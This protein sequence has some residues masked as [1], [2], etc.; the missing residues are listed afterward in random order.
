M[1]APYAG[2]DARIARAH[3]ATRSQVFRFCT[4][5]LRLKDFAFNTPPKQSNRPRK[6][7]QEKNSQAEYQFFQPFQ[8]YVLE[9]KPREASGASANVTESKHSCSEQKPAAG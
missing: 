6:W 9:K 1:N 5:S 4:F 8:Y 7:F 2:L 3:I